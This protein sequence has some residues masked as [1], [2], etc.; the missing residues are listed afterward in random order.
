[1]KLSANVFLN[2]P[3]NLP[4]NLSLS[5]P[6]P[7]GK[8]VAVYKR[9]GSSSGY[10]SPNAALLLIDPNAE[11]PDFLMAREVRAHACEVISGLEKKTSAFSKK[12]TPLT[13]KFASAWRTCAYQNY[14]RNNKN[15]A[16]SFNW[17]W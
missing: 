4:V 11:H 5:K 12:M 3:A 6:K 15:G 1:M 9:L 14:H 8:D 2:F 13:Y 7:T 16:F 10:S 17:L